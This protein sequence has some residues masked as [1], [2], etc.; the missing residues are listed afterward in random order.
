M[1]VHYNL[2]PADLRALQERRLIRRASNSIGAAFLIMTA[3]T[4]FLSA[5]LGLLFAYG[6]RNVSIL[7]DAGFLWLEQTFFSALGFVPPFILAAKLMDFRLSDLIGM[8]PVRASLC[9]PLVMVCMGAFLLG[10]VATSYLGQLFEGVGISPSQMSIAPPRGVWGTILY[11]L[12]VSAVPALVEEFALRGVVMNSL[13]R[14]GD[15]FAVFVSALLFGLMHGNLIQAPFAFVAG[16]ALGYADIAAG[17]LWPSI[18]AHLINN[19][20]AT[21]VTDGIAMA[22]AQMQD[23]LSVGY[24]LLLAVI[25][26]VGVLLLLREKPAAFRAPASHTAL[27]GGQKV[28]AFLLT[29]CMIF[30]LLDF[31]AT[32]IYVQF[33][34]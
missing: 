20:F 6:V 10:N 21:L 28:R 8:R 23:F 22:P 32:M 24:T 5:G 33:F 15:G 1:T 14:F 16:L 19:F 3:L 9:I 12:S 4:T 25:G 18:L 2:P 34:Y 27:S 7:Q 13:R 30:A 29:P 11:Y 26:I 31:A 17:S